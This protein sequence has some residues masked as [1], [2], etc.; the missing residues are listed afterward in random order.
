[1][2]VVWV[3]VEVTGVE[4]DV[5]KGLT[6]TQISLAMASFMVLSQ[7][8]TLLKKIIYSHYLKTTCALNLLVSC[9]HWYKHMHTWH[10]DENQIQFISKRNEFKKPEWPCTPQAT[11]TITTKHNYFFYETMGWEREREREGER[12]RERE[13]ERENISTNIW[14]LLVQSYAAFWGLKKNQNQR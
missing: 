13:R 7:P 4:A 5:D 8:T 10:K 12:E 6:F 9:I 11:K 3:T 14:A 2:A 1:M